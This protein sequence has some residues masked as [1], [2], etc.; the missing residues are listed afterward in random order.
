H[1]ESARIPAESLI[2]ARARL[3]LLPAPPHPAALGRTRTGNADQTV[4][5]GSV[6]YSP[7]P[8][9]GGAAIGV[10]VSGT[11]LVIVADL[12]ALP[13]RPQWAGERRGFVEVARHR[14]ST[15]RTARIDLAHYPDHPQDPAAASRPP[16][17]RARSQD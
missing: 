11:G 16:R 5:Y 15:P 4:R 9:L 6:R 1:R 10:R 2:D 13:L 17:P 7:P 12:D 14:L 3:H 8:G